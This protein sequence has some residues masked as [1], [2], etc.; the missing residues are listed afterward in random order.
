VRFRHGRD[1]G[2]RQRHFPRRQA[3]ARPLIYGPFLDAAQRVAG[4]RAARIALVLID[5][6]TGVQPD[7][8]RYT[9]AMNS[10]LRCE[11]TTIGVPIGS[12]LECAELDGA[13]GL[14]VGGGLTPAYADA[15]VPV[16]QQVVGWL[17][18]GGRPYCGFSAGA[19]IAARR[20]VIG[21]WRAGGVAVCP[22]DAGEDLDD[23]TVVGGLGL[24]D[25]SVDCHAEQWGTTP[26][27][28]AALGLP[29]SAGAGYAIDEDTALV[30]SGDESPR[31]VGL[32]KASR[33]D[34]S[35]G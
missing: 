11:T 25:F 16:R 31:I 1:G 4:S 15:V 19:A 14:L 30:M 2:S 5:E 20:A 32:G 6:G 7:A 12:T 10:V 33:I 26:R 13:H 28:A 18:E 3:S 21:G 22:E 35:A 34:L 8:S 29:D 23:V 9:A 17:V 27:L 24:V